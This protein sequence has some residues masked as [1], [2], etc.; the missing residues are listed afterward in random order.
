MGLSRRSRAGIVQF[1]KARNLKYSGKYVSFAQPDPNIDKFVNAFLGIKGV[2]N[3][4]DANKSR[5]VV[6]TEIPQES[7]GAGAGLP[8]A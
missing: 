1:N 7:S 2:E 8:T 6:G 3:D 5:E 4:S